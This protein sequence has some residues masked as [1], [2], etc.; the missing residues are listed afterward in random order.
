MGTSTTSVPGHGQSHQNLR[1]PFWGSCKTAKRL[2]DERLYRDRMRPLAIVQNSLL[3]SPLGV[4]KGELACV[5]ARSQ[6]RLRWLGGRNAPCLTPEDTATHPERPPPP[7]PQGGEYLDALDYKPDSPSDVFRRFTIKPADA[8]SERERETLDALRRE[9]R[10]GRAKIVVPADLPELRQ[11]TSETP[12][13]DNRSVSGRRLVNAL[14][15]VFKKRVHCI[16]G[17]GS[18]FPV[19]ALIFP[20]RLNDIALNV[21]SHAGIPYQV[22][23]E[24]AHSIEAQTLFWSRCL[25]DACHGLCVTI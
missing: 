20:D 14:V 15:L 4:G 12:K 9:Y 7:Q 13:S 6:I 1:T 22:G 11:S 2:L 19:Y 10:Q 18:A 17:T 3:F 23:H 21:D 25:R 8:L 5:A 16:T 24:L